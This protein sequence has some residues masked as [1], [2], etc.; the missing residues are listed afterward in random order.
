MAKILILGGG[1]SGLSAGICAQMNGHHAIVC[2]KHTVAG[3]NLTGWDRGGYHIDNCIHWLTGSNPA[4]ELYRVWEDLGALNES[5]ELYQAETLYTCERDGQQISLYRDLARLEREMLALSPRDARTIRAFV[6]T[7][8][9]IQGHVGIAGEEHDQ[10]LDA[11]GKLASLPGIIKHHWM[12]TGELAAHL[13]HP[14]L[15]DFVCAFVGK[16]FSAFALAVIIATFC[17][18]NGDIPKGSSC[19]ML[20]RI[21][22]RFAQLGGELHLKKEAVSIHCEGGYAKSVTFSDGSVIHADYVV[23]AFDPAMAYQNLLSS[24]MPK[25]LQKEYDRADMH[26][27]SSY[28]C[29]LACDAAELPFE[30]DYIFEIPEQYRTHLQTEHLVVR[31]F[32]HEKA[33]APEGKNI[34]QTLTLCGEEEAKEFIRLKED[35][36]AYAEKKRNI[37]DNVIEVLTHKFPSLKG[38]L[39]CLDVWTPAT[40]QR[41]TGSEIGSWMS[42]ILPP[43]RIPRKLDNRA[44]PFKNVVFATQW[45][46]APGGLPVAATEGKRAIDRILKKIAFK[47][48]P[49]ASAT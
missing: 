5:V 43:R 33:F 41:Y 19:A 45:L 49:V 42:F 29:A 47:K 16:Q 14:L 35:K 6:K 17:G 44:E 28:H 46:S 25:R 32:S 24:K 21:T 22:E 23:I 9:Y 11:F 27:F 40:Y 13:H 3:G 1:V 4:T 2:E 39:K 38:K 34:L 26:R 10:G 8:R 20:T 15:Q 30:S 7:V 37:A 12:S 48:R 36:A 18:E 31:E